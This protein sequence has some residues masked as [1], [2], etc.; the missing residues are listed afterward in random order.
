MAL[1]VAWPWTFTWNTADQD[2]DDD[3]LVC[4][5]DQKTT[6]NLI[7]IK[8][9]SKNVSSFSHFLS[10]SLSLSSLIRSLDSKMM[11]SRGYYYYYYYYYYYCCCCFVLL[12]RFL[13]LI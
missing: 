12:F 6:P 10:L 1:V 8:M 4:V 3:D 11:I 2:D 7:T 5:S 9:Y 13:I